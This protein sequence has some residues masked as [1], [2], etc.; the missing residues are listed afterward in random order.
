MS[1]RVSTLI[2][3]VSIVAVLAFHVLWAGTGNGQIAF[4]E[5]RLIAAGIPGVSAVAP[6]GTFLPGGPIPVNFESYTK[7]GKVLDPKRILVGS[8]SNFGEPLSDATQ[9]PGSFL[10]IDPTGLLSRLTSRSAAGR[11]LRSPDWYKCI[12]LRIKHF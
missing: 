11:R 4:L 1:K 9:L 7:P 12:A 2:V 6:V 10:S 3:F 5:G 8:T